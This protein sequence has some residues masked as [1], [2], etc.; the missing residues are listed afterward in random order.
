MTEK[1]WLYFALGVTTVISIGA[2]T[3]QLV[4]LAPATGLGTGSSAARV[5]TVK[6]VSK[7][8][9]SPESPA[10]RRREQAEGS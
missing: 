5:G 6:P 3:N 4:P 8:P 9:K 1:R 10:S 7:S 2:V